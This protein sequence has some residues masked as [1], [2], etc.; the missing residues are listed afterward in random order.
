M[1]MQILIVVCPICL[2]LVFHLLL[3]KL[4]ELVEKSFSPVRAI[5]TN[6]L[7]PQQ[8]VPFDT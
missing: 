6:C 1:N 3:K 4:I 7:V 2:K 5:T 8:S